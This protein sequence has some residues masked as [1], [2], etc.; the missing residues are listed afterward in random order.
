MSKKTKRLEK[1]NE[2]LKR[3]HEAMNQNIFKMAEERTRNMK[4]VEDAKRREE[5]LKS[6]IAQMQQQ[7]RGISQGGDGCHEDDGAEVDGEDSENE[8]EYEEDDLSDEDVEYAEDDCD[9][10][11]EEHAAEAPSSRP[12]PAPAPAPS[13]PVTTNGH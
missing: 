7:G 12:A 11:E 6:I 1:E 5:K 10:T 4:D 13:P 8:D 9:L 2:S 3:K